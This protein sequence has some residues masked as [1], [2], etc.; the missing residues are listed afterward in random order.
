MS[1][2]ADIKGQASPV[3]LR[4][5]FLDVAISQAPSERYETGWKN[6]LV[7]AFPNGT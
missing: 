5:T 2:S 4:S 6:G 7:P 1:T 3:M